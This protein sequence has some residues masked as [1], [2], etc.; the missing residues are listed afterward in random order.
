MRLRQRL[1]IDNLLITRSAQGLTVFTEDGGFTDIAPH[2]VEVFDGTGAGDSTISALTLA[3]AAGT[4]VVDAA[5]IGNAAGGAVVRKIGVATARADEI[6]AMFASSS[7]SAA[8][9]EGRT[10][11]A[12]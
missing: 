5:A 8:A 11:S 4:G 9:Q 1:G 10:A 6:A 12:S 7:P 2:L 3:L